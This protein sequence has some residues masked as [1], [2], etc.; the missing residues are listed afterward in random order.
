MAVRV[1]ATSE[2]DVIVIGGGLAGLG[3]ATALGDEYGKS[4]I[5][6]DKW[7]PK[8][9]GND[10]F[11]PAAASSFKNAGMFDLGTII[12][13]VK[14][15]FSGKTAE[16]YEKSGVDLRK[17]GAYVM[18]SSLFDGLAADVVLERVSKRTFQEELE[19]N[20]RLA[21][22]NAAV[23]KFSKGSQ[24]EPESAMK[25]LIELAEAM[26]Q[27]ELRYGESAA[28][29][30]YEAGHWTIRSGSGETLR[31][32]RLVIAAGPGSR[33][34]LR[35]LG[36]ELPVQR[37]YGVIA[38]SQELEDP[39]LKGSI[40]GAKSYVYWLTRTFC[41]CF[42]GKNPLEAT[43]W[44]GERRSWTTH[45]Y[46]NVHNNRIYLGGPRFGIRGGSPDES[47]EAAWFERQIRR[48]EAYSRELIE[49]PTGVSFAADQTWGGMMVFPADIDYP[50]V[51]PLSGAFNDSLFLSTGYAS[52]GF[53]EAPGAGHFLACL[54]EEGVEELKRKVGRENLRDFES[55]LP[56]RRVRRL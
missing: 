5:V 15:Y 48:T 8:L 33:A 19:P 10:R 20:V 44:F 13:G 32:T 51:G 49:Y 42:I 37:V 16:L 43:S 18:A 30:R 3:V 21:P 27:V 6:L 1:R 50:F 23:L 45:L 53:R 29:I 17:E 34:L 52:A 12:P 11:D 46:L 35:R 7:A 40:L 26:S 36:Y 25:K 47:F 31:A 4:V 54:M 39:W 22:S 41:S 2:A 28:G 9:D 38:Q 24:A 14:E 56:S 55:V